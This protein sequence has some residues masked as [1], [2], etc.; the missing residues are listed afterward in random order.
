MN[1][2]RYKSFKLWHL[3]NVSCR[4]S[5]T[6]LCIYVSSFKIYYFLIWFFWW[7]NKLKN[8][9]FIKINTVFFTASTCRCFPHLSTCQLLFGK[10]Q[11]HLRTSLQ[12]EWLRDAVLIKIVSW[13]VQLFQLS[14]KV[15]TPPPLSGAKLR[16][17]KILWL[18]RLFSASSCWLFSVWL[19]LVG[20]FRLLIVW[21]TKKR[22]YKLTL[23]AEN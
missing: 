1:Q 11:V 4:Y 3:W 9:L 7:P 20:Q 14:N 17:I 8:I 6:R 16:A 19:S 22:E 5:Y 12:R 10:C 2:N 15:L 18:F 23:N 21:V 13:I